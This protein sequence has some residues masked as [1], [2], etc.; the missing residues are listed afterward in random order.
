MRTVSAGFMTEMV[1]QNLNNL[2]RRYI[3]NA[4]DRSSYPKSYGTI[5]LDAK[6][7]VTGRVGLDLV[8]SD[9]LWNMFLSNIANLRQVATIDLGIEV[10]GTPEYVTFFTGNLDET[11]FI[12]D[13]LNCKL[14]NKMVRMLE[15]TIGS[16]DTPVNLSTAAGGNPATIVWTILTNAVWGGELD[17]T[18]GVANV[19]IAYTSWLQWQTDCTTLGLLLAMRLTGQ[20]IGW[21]LDRVAWLTSSTIFVRGDGRFVFYRYVPL[22]I[23]YAIYSDGN[24]HLIEVRQN[25]DELLNDITCEWGWNG[26]AWGGAAVTNS[27]A[28]SQGRWGIVSRIEND[29]NI[30]HFNAASAQEFCD[31][32]IPRYKDPHEHCTFETGLEGFINEPN[33]LIYLTIPFLGYSSSIF[34]ITKIEFELNDGKARIEAV[35]AVTWASGFFILDHPIYGLLDQSYNPLF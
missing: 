7:I 13:Y 30:Y 10:A 12:R 9:Q 8:N 29:R 4:I 1:R 18:A 3:Y 22:P 20:T 19:D 6:R 26:A 16:V 23:V 24:A 28:T 14:R 25:F 15:K 31:R 32:V 21:I 27:D 33:D 11:Y 5:T 34:E 17:N 35:N 2:H